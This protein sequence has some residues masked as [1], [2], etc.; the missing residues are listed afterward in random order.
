M[1]ISRLLG[2]LVLATASCF[3][4]AVPMATM[5]FDVD[6]IG[7]AH[8]PSGNTLLTGPQ[9]SKA[10]LSF[11]VQ[12]LNFGTSVSIYSKDLVVPLSWTGTQKLVSI[13]SAIDQYFTT[14]LMGNYMHQ[15]LSELGLSS[16]FTAGPSLNY[17]NLLK[18][19]SAG[20][21]ASK[22]YNMFDSSSEWISYDVEGDPNA[23]F[24]SM[25]RLTGVGDIEDGDLDPFQAT[26]IPQMLLDIAHSTRGYTL[27]YTIFVDRYKDIQTHEGPTRPVEITYGGT[28]HLT[29]FSI[30]GQ[31]FLHTEVPEPSTF[32]LSALGL[33][34]CLGLRLKRREHGV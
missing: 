30:D 8:M 9:N 29:G 31:D 21:D 19:Q 12:T 27:Q 4:H 5:T 17:A 2:T 15:G 32:A 13:S 6:F 24:H 33:V 34:A 16:N 22:H 20:S 18:R 25:I 26:D 28:A 7:I 23:L 14:D 3:A 10:T 11:P 1:N